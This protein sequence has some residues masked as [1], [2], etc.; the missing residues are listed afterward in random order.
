[1]LLIVAVTLLLTMS[2]TVPLVEQVKPVDAS[3]PI[4][5]DA[6]WKEVSDPRLAELGADPQAAAAG[7]APIR[8]VPIY[9]ASIRARRTRKAA[10]ARKTNAYDK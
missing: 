2:V 3:T 1:M 5:V 7:P 6:T 10:N 9:T 8:I 4:G